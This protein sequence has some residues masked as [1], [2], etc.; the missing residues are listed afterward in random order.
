MRNDLLQSIAA[1]IADYRQGEVIRITPSHVNRWVRQFDDGDQGIILEEMDR[2][3]QRFYYSRTRSKRSLRS[4]IRQGMIGD[5]EPRSALSRTRFLRVQQQGNSQKDLLEIVDEILQED[6]GMRIADCGADSPDT[7]VYID[8]GIYT[9]SRIRYDL[10]PGENAPSWITNEA[11]EGSKLKIHVLAS[12]K[13]GEKYAMGIIR[14]CA[15]RRHIVVDGMCDVRIANERQLGGAECLW[16]STVTGN[17]DVDSYVSDVRRFLANK[18]ASDRLLFRPPSVP[19]QETLFTSSVARET[20]ERAFLVKGAELVQSTDKA[21]MRPL[22]W[23]K[24]GSLGFGT[25][26]VTYRN[27]ANNAPLVLWWGGGGWYPLFSPKR[28]YTSQSDPDTDVD[29]FEGFDDLPF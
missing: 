6:H 28:M 16:P 8:D 26:F 7:F 23:E 25:L 3:L 1:T 18:G 9:G 27:I 13:A 11:P 12:H 29:P 2:L 19:K 10:T 15:R 14:P 5:N 17:P 24:L 20:V 22:G 21:S 4:Y